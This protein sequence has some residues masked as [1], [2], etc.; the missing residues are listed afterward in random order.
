V[1]LSRFFTSPDYLFWFSPYYL[2]FN[3]GDEIKITETDTRDYLNI[4]TLKKFKNPKINFND[5]LK[6]LYILSEGN[7]FVSEKLIP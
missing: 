5:S 7:L 2:I 3:V 6:K 4:V 1:F